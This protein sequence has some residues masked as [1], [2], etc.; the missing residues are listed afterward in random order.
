[1]VPGPS[2]AAGQDTSGLR[3]GELP[4]RL[5]PHEPSRDLVLIVGTAAPSGR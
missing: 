4:I 3:H 5:H 1:M 2:A